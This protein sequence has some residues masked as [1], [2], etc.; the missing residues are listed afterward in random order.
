MNYAVMEEHMCEAY[1]QG[2]SIE[3]LQRKFNY[4]KFM[5]L[6]ILQ[7]KGL[8]KLSVDDALKYM[9]EGKVKALYNAGWSN[10]KI[11]SEYQLVPPCVVNEVIQK[12]CI[13]GMDNNRNDYGL[14]GCDA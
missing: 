5:I 1:K 8:R 6:V 14:C 2:M 10:K 13:D 12:V 11:Q 4:S 3:Q 9:D 7:E